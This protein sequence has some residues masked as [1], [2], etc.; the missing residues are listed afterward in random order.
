MDD[1]DA[2]K[3]VTRMREV[4]L[5]LLKPFVN[6]IKVHDDVLAQRV[7]RRSERRRWSLGAG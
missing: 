6:G 7:I 5:V 3:R 2:V 4:A 1:L